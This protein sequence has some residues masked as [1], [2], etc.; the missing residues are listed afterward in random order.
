MMELF[1]KKKAK[2]LFWEPRFYVLSS[3]NTEVSRGITHTD[4]FKAEMKQLQEEYNCK[5]RRYN[6][7]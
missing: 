5:L 7:P 4:E 1:R 2:V 6:A 3:Y